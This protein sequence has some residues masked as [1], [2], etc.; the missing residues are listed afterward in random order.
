MNRKQCTRDLLV[1][2]KSFMIEY[3]KGIVIPLISNSIIMG[4]LIYILHPLVH[5]ETSPEHFNQL[6]G[7]QVL[8]FYLGVIAFLFIVHLIA[9]FFMTVLSAYILE[10]KNNNKPTLT[11]S[12][13]IILKQLH[14]I[15]LWFLYS[16]FF[17]FLS[18]L[19]R[20]FI[21]N[22]SW[23]K[24]WLG[25]MNWQMATFLTIPLLTKKFY[26]PFELIKESRDLM[27]NTW[28][29]PHI[30]NFGFG[31]YVFL[32]RITAFLPAIIAALIAAKPTLI[33]C[34]IISSILLILVTSIQVYT[35][36]LIV[37]ACYESAVN[38]QETKYFN[39]KTISYALKP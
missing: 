21:R 1:S 6:T 25:S 2:C 10:T 9:F 8:F 17:G 12:F 5:Y 22:F 3:K 14:S 20:Y 4:L 35:N 7:E 34:V 11:H 39:K 32:G 23:Y 16:S 30:Q 36:M 24:R 27:I 28:G 38:N 15:S 26:Y 37:C 33:I 13:K 29:T 19:F 31:G 18:I